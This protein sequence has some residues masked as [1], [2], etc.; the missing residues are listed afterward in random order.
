MNAIILA[1]STATRIGQLVRLL[2]SDKSGEIVAAATAIKRTLIGAGMDMHK[3]AAIAERGLQCPP[4]R[5]LSIVEIIHFCA[6]RDGALN[7]REAQF[8]W[9]LEG[10]VL[11]FGEAFEPSEKQR[12]WLA[13]IYVKLRS[14][15]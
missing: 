9:S 4:R 1:S 8:V 12:A 15:R 10:Q 7:E 2:G 3:L 14:D 11:R 6:A 5:D 13:N